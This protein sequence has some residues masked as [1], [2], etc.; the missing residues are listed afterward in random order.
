MKKSISLPF[1]FR[2]S[3][4]TFSSQLPKFCGSFVISSDCEGRLTDWREILPYIVCK[5][6]L[7]STRELL[8][9]K[10]KKK[11]F[12]PPS[13]DVN[14]IDEIVY[15]SLSGDKSNSEPWSFSNYWTSNFHPTSHKFVPRLP[16][17]NYTFTL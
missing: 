1:Q 13:K 8:E 5:L 2:V 9:W 6:K 10:I 12:S 3:L 4:S 14:L 17:R 7:Q 16:P 11:D 15:W